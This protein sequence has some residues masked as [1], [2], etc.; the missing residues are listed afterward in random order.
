MIRIPVWVGML[1]AF[2]L[3][4]TAWI[5]AVNRASD[6]QEEIREIL[7]GSQAPQAREA[8]TAQA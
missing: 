5:W 3:L 8:D 1:I 4:T 7:G 2:S 6:H